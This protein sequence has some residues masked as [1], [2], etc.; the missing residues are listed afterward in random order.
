MFRKFIRGRLLFRISLCLSLLVSTTSWLAAVTPF[1]GFKI[2]RRNFNRKILRYRVLK[3]LSAATA[4]GTRHRP[5]AEIRNIRRQRSARFRNHIALA[6]TIV[7][8]R[9]SDVATAPQH[10]ADIAAGFTS[11]WLSALLL[12]PRASQA[13]LTSTRFSSPTF[14]AFGGAA[15][16]PISRRLRRNAFGHRS[17]RVLPY[18]SPALSRHRK[19]QR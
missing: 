18:F 2:S 13:I 4:S 11:P 15:C 12:R 5:F 6:L 8:R 10:P 9:R 16:C 14:C 17:P 7:L 19:L 3:S 1:T